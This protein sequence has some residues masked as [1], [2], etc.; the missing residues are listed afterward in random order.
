VPKRR[1]LKLNSGRV[2]PV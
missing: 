2:T 1:K